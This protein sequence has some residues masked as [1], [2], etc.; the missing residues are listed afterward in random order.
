L[1]PPQEAW[2]S[3]LKGCRPKDKPKYQRVSA[4][5]RASM[6]EQQQVPEVQIAVAKH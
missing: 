2:G 5:Q 3:I 4:M 6:L 1:P